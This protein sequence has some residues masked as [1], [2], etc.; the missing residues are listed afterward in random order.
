MG[1]KTHGE[2]LSMGESSK[3]RDKRL[4][5]RDKRLEKKKRDKRLEKKNR[6]KSRHKIRNEERR[7]KNDSSYSF[8]HAQTH[9]A[10]T[11]QLTSKNQLTLAK[12]NN[13]LSSFAWTVFAHFYFLDARRLERIEEKPIV[14]RLKRAY[15]IP[16]TFKNHL[17]KQVLW[18]D[19]D[20]NASRFYRNVEL[21]TKQ[22]VNCKCCERH[23]HAKFFLN[24]QPDGSFMPFSTR[25]E[26]VF[27][28]NGFYISPY[29]EPIVE[30]KQTNWVGTKYQFFN[31]T[32][33]YRLYFKVDLENHFRRTCPGRLH[34]KKFLKPSLR[35][36]GGEGALITSGSPFYGSCSKTCFCNCRHFGR[37]LVEMLFPD[38]RFNFIR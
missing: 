35:W 33:M 11:S 25:Y 3:K 14:D 9:S 38:S 20:E 36:I 22:L 6:D 12:Q 30:E 29:G 37:S 24:C 34:H 18:T 31:D 15:S 1:K 13:H 19:S 8:L 7:Q 17:M 27:F 5:K 26:N 23:Q 32:S 2:N 10:S 21:L 28:K 16:I 4:E